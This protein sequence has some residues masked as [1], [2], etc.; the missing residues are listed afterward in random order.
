MF[1]TRGIPHTNGGLETFFMEFAPRL[2]ARGHE[3][4]GYCRRSHFK[5]RP[6]SYKGVRLVYLPSIE[7]KEL[8][9]PVHSLLCAF[10]VLFRRVDVI[11][12][13]NVAHAFHCLIPRLFGK[14]VAINVDGLDWK[15]G[16]WGSFGR[17]YFYWNAKYV[18]RICSKGVITDAREM[19]RVY[20]QELGTPSTCIAYGA[21]VE[22]SSRPEIL[23]QYGLE[24]F[25]YYLIASRLVPENNPDLI[26]N[27]FQQ[28][29]TD[30]L[31]VIAGAAHYRS[32][33]SERLKRSKD[34]RVRFLG[35]IDNVEHIK[36]LHCNAYGYI[37]GHS[38]GGTN[39][40][41]LKALG[42]GNCILALRTPFNSEVLGDYG[43][44]FDHDVRD[45]AEKITQIEDHPEVAAEFR[46][47]APDRIR[48][49]YTWEKITDQ[50]EELFQQ[51]AA[52][53]DPTRIHST[54]RCLAGDK[55]EHSSVAARTAT[56]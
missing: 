1:G 46:R 26:V 35:H 52:G 9:T 3:V 42:Y 7:T 30:R 6:P 12:V 17:K 51:L 48:Q 56:E 27:A 16:K 54:V 44:F 21:N 25:Q 31:L 55:S 13:V 37:H 19:Q 24:P 43:A 10:D 45:L 29:R 23:K 49:A 20:W 18:G 36:E 38:M 4:I 33:F 28:A 15:R 39:P 34:P 47:R 41:L 53:E 32:E 5:D 11:F 8:G 50:Y 14:K 22:T 40:A 2:A